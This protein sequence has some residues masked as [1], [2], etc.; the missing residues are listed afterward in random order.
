MQWLS[1]FKLQE[2]KLIYQIV[3]DISNIK[4]LGNT[5]ISQ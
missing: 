5:K 3:E 4:D 2:H 1:P